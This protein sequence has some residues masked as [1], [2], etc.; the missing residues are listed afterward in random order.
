MLSRFTVMIFVA[1]VG[2]K[3]RFLFGRPRDFWHS[4]FHHR[5]CF[6]GVNYDNLFCD[7]SSL[8]VWERFLLTGVSFLLHF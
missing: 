6:L 1:I 3:L 2:G 5:F 4:I 8:G 7:Y